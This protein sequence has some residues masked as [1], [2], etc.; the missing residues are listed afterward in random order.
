MLALLAALLVQAPVPALDVTTSTDRARVVVGEEIVFTLRAVGHSTAAFRAD[1][2][3]L[4]GFALTDRQEH[5]DVVY[6]RKQLTRSYT[7]ELH[8][9]AEAVGTWTIGPIRVEHGEASAFSPVESVTV[10][11]A[12]GGAPSGLDPGLM[13][14][15]PRV[16]P[17]R[18]GGPSV[19]IVTSAELVYAGDQVD[20]LTAAWLPRSL[21]MRLRQPPTLS[22]PGVLGV[23]SAPRAAVPGA[24][25]SRV[26]DGETYD[27]F[28]GFQTVFPLNPGSIPIP[29]ARLAWTQPAGR[30]SSGGDSRRSTES[31]PLNLVVRPLP[32]AGRPTGFNGPVARE[33]RIEYRLGQNAARA[34]AV[35]PVDVLVSGR[36]NISLWA[37]PPLAWP[38][39]VRA[40]EEGT[41]D[42][43]R[44]LGG[45]LGGSRKFRFAVVPDS[46]GSLSLPPLEYAYFDPADG[47][48]RVARTSGVVVPVLDATPTRD[49]RS[50]LPLEVVGA[51]SPVE[52]IIGLPWYALALLTALPLLA[53]GLALLTGR[54]HARPVSEPV[55]GEPAERLD[56]LLLGLVPPDSR[57][58]PRALAAAL[59]T[60]GMEREAAERLVQLH[61]A[62]SAERFGR[63]GDGH[64]SRELLGEIAAALGRLPR[65]LRRWSPQAAVLAGLALLVQTARAAPLAA[66][67]AIELYNRG[68]YAAAAAAFGREA[69]RARRSGALWYDLAAAEYMT[70]RD[71]PAAAA[72]LAARA[73]AP[74]DPRVSA[75]WSALAREHAQLRRAGAGWPLTAEEWFLAALA[76]LWLGALLFVVLRRR[77]P[78]WPAFLLLAALG[79]AAGASARAAR[80]APRAVLTG[81]VSL[82]VSPH[83]LAPERG[84]AAAFSIVRLERRQGGWWLVRTSDDTEGW[85]MEEILALAPALD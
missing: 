71:A 9:R 30:Q 63:D 79:A 61:G 27:L 57:S 16:P 46:A 81:G 37:A 17:P 14:M 1:L 66:Q 10:T 22:P 35:L 78:L 29:S 15:L 39:G 28:V 56:A 62:L 85:V 41:E 3:A 49:P 26:V 21:R 19:F 13:A 24:V 18:A 5:V 50:A 77:L 12:S 72:L 51:P 80:A 8:L 48:Y 64:G 2:P 67:P 69:T 68:E 6:G 59:R 65:R 40:Y 32:A 44:L 53:M 25:A 20:V 33:L 74:R 23:W 52:R 47:V 84:T 76:A 34:A 7:L 11:N 4:D 82:R 73:L 60:A 43:P 42:A 38:G 36:G 83:G 55:S 45:R 54:R 70:R 58:S 75:L 31:R